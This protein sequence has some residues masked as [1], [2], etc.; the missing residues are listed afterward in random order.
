MCSTWERLRESLVRAMGSA[1]FLD[2][3]RRATHIKPA[4]GRFRDPT[5]LVDY[6]VGGGRD[7]DDK[8]AVYTALIELARAGGDEAKT[9]AAL[10][11]L[12]LWPGLDAVYRRRLAWCPKTDCAE[13][14]L[15]ADVVSRFTHA[16]HST[17]LRDGGRVAATL[18]R[19]TERDVKRARAREA[20]LAAC[21]EPLADHNNLCA[22][23]SRSTAR[24]RAILPDLPAGLDSD[25]EF[26]SLRERIGAC[27]GRDVDLVLAVAVG[28][29]DLREMS[30]RLGIEYEAA[31]K[32][33]ARTIKRLRDSLEESSEH[34]SQIDLEGGVSSLNRENARRGGF[35][36]GRQAPRT[37]S[38]HGAH[39]GRHRRAS[40]V[41][42][43][44]WPLQA[45]GAR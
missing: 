41:P 1:A 38:H 17:G 21:R 35:D 6:L 3:F 39:P 20:K 22:P 15:V 33:Y 10:I 42:A 5:G 23:A 7:L 19:N 36:N 37:G 8:D 16:V 27:A 30:E 2:S 14:D 45:L 25:A 40:R 12:G 9:A 28:G 34:M 26:A 18:V 31:R 24:H 13:D 29:Y 44:A 4:L 43:R 32:R 11:W